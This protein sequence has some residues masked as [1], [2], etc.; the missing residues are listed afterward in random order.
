MKKK[1]GFLIIAH[2]SRKAEA[3]EK[4]FALVKHLKTYFQSELFESALMELATPS[5][6]DG[7]NSLI[8]KEVTEIVAFP[9]FLFK[10]MHYTRD[11]PEII[12]KAIE[13]SGKDI[14]IIMLPPIGE[15]PAV[16]DLV[17]EM[18][19]DEVMEEVV[20]KQV[21]PTAIEDRSMELIEAHI[22]QTDMPA[23]RK[24]IIKR[25]I[26]TTG[27]FDFLNNMIFSE[28]AVEAG[29]KA[30]SEKRTI[31]TDVT[32]VQAGINKRQGHEVKC[33]LNDP[34][35]AEGAKAA[36]KTKTAFSVE[37]LGEALN[38]NI[39]AIG[40]AP[41]ALITLVKMVQEKGIKPALIV[42]IPVGFVNA[43]ESK[44]LLSQL[45]GVPFITNKGHK[46]GSTV[47]AAIV[48]ALIKMDKE[49]NK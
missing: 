35:V 12:K 39:I 6:E 37:N 9:F 43:K 36:G 49:G 46:G 45:K 16:F 44:A 23:N 8:E 31:Y 19:Y 5:I 28:G 48:N 13:D 33:T 32:M 11:V 17:G 4:V 18:I 47:A 22:D 1:R 38:G 29:L 10:G 7:I 41:T 40:N 2:G 25:A 3:N 14:P 42:G 24:P 20:V 27:D 30:I 26:H 34:G 15:H 21:E